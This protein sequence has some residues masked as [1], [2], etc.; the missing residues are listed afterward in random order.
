MLANWAQHTTTSS[1]SGNLA[2]VAVTN[3]PA[4]ND[5]VGLNRRFAY[6][7]QDDATGRPIEAGIGY[8]SNATTL[9]R[10]RPTATWSGGVYDD[11][12]PAAVNLSAGT[13]RV[14]ST[15]TAD[16]IQGAGKSINRATASMRALF[17]QHLTV[18]NASSNGAALQANRAV[19]MPFWLTTSADID[20]LVVRV[21]TGVAGTSL[22]MALYDVGA[23]G[24][25]NALLAETASLSSATSGVDLIGTFPQIR[26][27]PGWYYVGVISDG[28]PTLGRVDN[29]GQLQSLMGASSGNSIST[30]GS[31]VYST[32]YGPFPNPAMNGL[33]QSTGTG[34]PS[35]ALRV[36]A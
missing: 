21:G 15:G 9:V 24:N 27:Q 12:S 26:L 13:Y 23:D 18:N 30:Y 29:S 2:L 8:L 28:A 17:S 33:V 32:T 5:V 11:T 20:A 19:I 10:E 4:I 34:N 7:I 22:R 3:Y 36:A 35:I 16:A 14:I 1:G 6:V 25:A 31:W